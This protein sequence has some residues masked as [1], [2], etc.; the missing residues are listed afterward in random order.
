MVGIDAEKGTITG[1]KVLSHSETPGLGARSTE[2]EWQ[3]QFKGK[4]PEK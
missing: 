2:P 4:S 1:I 3:A